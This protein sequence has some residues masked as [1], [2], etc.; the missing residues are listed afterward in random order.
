LLAFDCTTFRLDFGFA[1]LRSELPAMAASKKV[2]YVTRE[3]IERYL[4]LD[5]QRLSFGRQAKALAAEQD[6]IEEQLVEFVRAKGGPGKRCDRSGFVLALLTKRCQPHWKDAFIS[7]KGAKAAEELI[8]SA[9]TKEVL[10][11]ERTAA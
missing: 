8:Q 1:R 5:E 3:M 6:A 4:Q 7:A 10:S 9:P 11:V 2:P